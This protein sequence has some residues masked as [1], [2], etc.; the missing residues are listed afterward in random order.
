MKNLI[1]IGMPG[2]GKSTVGA[3]LSRKYALPFIDGDRVIENEMGMKLSQILDLHGQEGFR[4]IESRILCSISP[5]SA[6]IAPGGSCI[7]GPEAMYH[8]RR[9]GHVIY[10]Q[11][12]YETI[13][14]RLGDLHARGITFQPGQ[15]LRDLYEERI[16]LY[17][18]Y[19]DL[20]IYTDGKT[21]FEVVRSIQSLLSKQGKR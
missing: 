15:S 2:C 9:I 20:I 11:A 13:A 5:R 16:P 8:F 18:K 7:Y 17:R 21:L 1:L 19:A 14:S 4:A 3:E 12:S 6:V 10:L